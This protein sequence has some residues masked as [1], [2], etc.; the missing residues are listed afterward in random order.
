MKLNDIIDENYEHV[1]P[2]EI[3]QVNNINQGVVSDLLAIFQSEYEK[4]AQIPKNYTRLDLSLYSQFS[5]ALEQATLI[6]TP[7]DI[8][9]FSVCLHEFETMPIL[10]KA[11]AML[12]ALINYHYKKTKTEERVEKR[13]GEGEQ[14]RKEEEWEKEEEK[15]LLVTSH[16]EKRLDYLGWKNDGAHIR[17]RGDVGD[18]AG[19]QM[20]NGSLIIEGSAKSF[21]GSSMRDGFIEV[22][23]NAEDMIGYHMHG[24]EIDLH[25]NAMSV[26]TGMY[27]GYIIVRGDISRSAGTEMEGGRIDILGSC[28]S[29]NHPPEMEVYHQ[30]KKVESSLKKIK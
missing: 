11:G 15:Y 18:G 28:H 8:T 7:E 14:K 25:K 22:F 27:D 1:S 24:G 2:E 12:S 29:F 30:G 5:N 9:T 20:K 17:I 23:Q 26:G 10:E 13:E 16:L 21:L 4:D 6:Y 19:A 3:K